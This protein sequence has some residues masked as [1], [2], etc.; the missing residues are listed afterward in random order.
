M[1]IEAIAFLVI[2]LGLTLAG[3][4]LSRGESK[5]GNSG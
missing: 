1:P 2:V 4:L 3:W 5:E